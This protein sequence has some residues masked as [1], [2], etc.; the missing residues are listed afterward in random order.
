MLKSLIHT[1]KCKNFI[2]LQIMKKSYETFKDKDLFPFFNKVT[3]KTIVKLRDDVQKSNYLYKN[4]FDFSNKKLFHSMQILHS[5]KIFGFSN[6][7][8]HSLKL[9]YN[10][11]YSS[12]YLLNFKNL[13]LI[14]MST[15]LTENN[16]LIRLLSKELNNEKIDINKRKLIL[17]SNLK[18]F[19]F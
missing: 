8:L 14:L 10:F 1:I 15:K 2:Y 16:K 19:N 4:N 11:C 17:I 3:S 6:W 7:K 9:D 13:P 18:K 5:I 12:F